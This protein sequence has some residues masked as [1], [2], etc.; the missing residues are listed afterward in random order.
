[1]QLLSAVQYHLTSPSL[2]SFGGAAHNSWGHIL[3]GTTLMTFNPM[4]PPNKKKSCPTA[5]YRLK[6][7]G[8]LSGHS[9]TTSG[10]LP[11]EYASTTTFCMSPV[12]IRP[13][14]VKKAGLYQ[15]PSIMSMIV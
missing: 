9:N 2:R 15:Q 7:N 4:N 12:T 1:M 14:E 11:A 5:S 10:E 8:K 3:A 13:N 6:K